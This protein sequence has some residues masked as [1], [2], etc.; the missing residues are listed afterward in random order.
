MSI[1][2]TT[3]R[4]TV[5]LPHPVSGLK[6]HTGRH[7]QLP[8]YRGD[9]SY[10]RTSLPFGDDI[11]FCIHTIAQ[12]L[13]TPHLSYM[14]FV[15]L[16]SVKAEHGAS[17]S[18]RRSVRDKVTDTACRGQPEMARTVNRLQ[19]EFAVSLCCLFRGNEGGKEIYYIKNKT[20]G[21]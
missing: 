17:P 1:I 13:S 3:V 21:L 16:L 4:T 2:Y 6:D 14:W 9:N 8:F 19:T 20:T 5:S 18:V 7:L 12:D 15:V 10:T 11:L